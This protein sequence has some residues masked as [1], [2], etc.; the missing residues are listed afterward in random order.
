MSGTVYRCHQGGYNIVEVMII[1]AVVGLVIGASI[2]PLRGLWQGNVDR[3][4]MEILRSHQDSIL[5][6]A[7]IHRTMPREVVVT[8]ASGYSS[9]YVLPGGRPYLPCPDVDGD[10]YE[11]RSGAPAPGVFMDDSDYVITDTDNPLLIAGN[12]LLSRGIL[13]WK[14]LGVE[15]ADHWGNRYTYAVDDIFSS[16][17]VGFNQDTIADSFDYRMTVS[18]DGG[19]WHYQRRDEFAELPLVTGDGSPIYF[20]NTRTPIVVCDGTVTDVC[21]DTPGLVLLAGNLV[22]TAG[23]YEATRRIYAQNDVI[24]GAVYV[25]VSHGA[26]GHGAVNHLS[27]N[28]ADYALVCRPPIYRDLID[29]A[30]FNIEDDLINEAVNFPFPEV[31]TLP[32]AVRYCPPL[33][34]DALGLQSGFFVHAPRTAPGGGRREYDDILVWSMRQ[35]LLQVLTAAHKLPAAAVPVMRSY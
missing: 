24:E 32:M 11:D 29:D 6:Y 5:G 18:F 15:A 33:T 31:D 35:E 34:V 13:P 27:G 3:E 17:V 26:N 20:R 22:T 19:D 4:Q 9:R 30:E 28:V 21:T 16:A 12:C 25:I 8:G 10:G 1:L 7:L 23:G 2:V 14:T